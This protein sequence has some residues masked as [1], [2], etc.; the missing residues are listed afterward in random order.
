MAAIGLTR[1]RVIALAKLALMAAPLAWLYQK[2]SWDH[3]AADAVRFGALPFLFTSAL[4]ALTVTLNGVRWHALL[5][6]HD[7]WPLPTRR[8]LVSQSFVALYLNQLP[9][10]V[11]G[12]VVRAHHVRNSAGGSGPSLVILMFERVCGLV[13]LFALATLGA[14]ALPVSLGSYIEVSGLVTGAITLI[15]IAL[16]WWVPKVAWEKT[17]VGRS[18]WL[19]SN[20][21]RLRP[22]KRLGPMLGALALSF[23]IHSLTIAAIGCFVHSAAPSVPLA[24]IV[25]IT[26]LAM[27]LTFIPITPGGFGQREAIFVQLYG[28]AGVSAN[29]AVA[30]SLLWFASAFVSVLVGLV[31]GTI[32]ARR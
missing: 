26:P 7:A 4:L 2:V 5:R 11:A 25:A 23:V 28:L 14:L 20:L 31:L 12:D 22:P 15:V 32:Q 24:S 19:T 27:L 13:A 9:G 21:S 3:V 29:E 30:A 10:G 1:T 8:E 16:P 17:I 6:A 18:P